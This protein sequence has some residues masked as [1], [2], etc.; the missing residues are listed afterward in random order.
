[1]KKRKEELTSYSYVEK[2]KDFNENNEVLTS[3]IDDLIKDYNTE[4]LTLIAISD[5]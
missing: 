1:L 4:K 2:V 3:T 5:I